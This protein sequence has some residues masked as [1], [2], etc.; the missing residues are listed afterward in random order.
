MTNKTLIWDRGEALRFVRA[1]LIEL[2]LV[3]TSLG[4][5]LL[6]YLIEM[7]YTESDDV[8][9]RERLRIQG[10][11]ADPEKPENED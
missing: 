8:I 2:R 7:A 4:L 11:I 9:R 3:T 6:G 5:P 1:Q 10:E